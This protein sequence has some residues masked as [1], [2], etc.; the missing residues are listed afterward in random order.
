MG[1][2]TLETKTTHDTTVTCPAVKW[3]S[4]GNQKNKF[5][6]SFTLIFKPFFNSIRP[7]YPVPFYC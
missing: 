4:N 1:R 3:K 2:V 7:F 5:A 6:T